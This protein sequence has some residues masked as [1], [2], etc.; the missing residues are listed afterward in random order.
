MSS[1]GQKDGD[2]EQLCMY[3]FDSF[4]CLVDRG[5]NYFGEYGFGLKIL[6]VKTFK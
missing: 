3:G 1:E 2:V 4:M 6:E 5:A